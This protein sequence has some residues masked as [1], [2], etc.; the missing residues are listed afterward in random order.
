LI[1]ALA[2]LAVFPVRQSALVPATLVAQSPAIVRAPIDGV[3]ERFEVQPNAMVRQG[4]VL[5]TLDITKLDSRLK[6]VQ[7]SLEVSQ[8][9]LRQ[10]EQKAV[11]DEASRATLAILKSRVQQQQAEVDYVRGLIERSQVRSP[12]DGMAVFDNVNDWLGRP[13]TVGEKILTLA[14][15]KEMELEMWLPVSDAMLFPDQAQVRLFLNARPYAPVDATLRYSSY[16]AQMT[17]EGH[18]AYRLVATLQET[19]ESLRIGLK[20]SAKVYGDYSPL[21][22]YLLRKPIVAVRQYLGW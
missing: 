9:E 8:A 10:A 3:V 1:G 11:F 7:R 20:G 6:V 22:M 4:D 13:V 19:P 15:P 12:R 5:L 14:A 17:P 18:F 21:F 2:L 16:E